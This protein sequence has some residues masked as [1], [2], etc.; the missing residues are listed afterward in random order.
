MLSAKFRLRQDKDFTRVFRGGRRA[1]A[2]LVLITF[3]PNRLREPRY[4]VVVGTKVSKR[5]VVRNRLKRRIR[6]QL[7]LLIKDKVVRGGFD[8][9]VSVRPG[10]DKLRAAILEAQVEAALIRA[11]LL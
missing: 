6:E 1:S 2:G 9:I 3:S 4:A 7:R 5:A 8:A 10:A 11:R